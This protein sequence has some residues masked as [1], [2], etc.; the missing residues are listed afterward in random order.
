M[1]GCKNG[2]STSLKVQLY[3]K[4]KQD[5][6]NKRIQPVPNGKYKNTNM[7]VICQMQG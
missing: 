1:R 4:Q 7:F 5:N 6:N 3:Q 2:D